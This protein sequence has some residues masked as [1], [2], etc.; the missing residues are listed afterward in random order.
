MKFRFVHVPRFHRPF[1]SGCISGLVPFPCS[2]K[3]PGC[4]SISGVWCG[5]LWANQER[6]IQIILD[7]I[8]RYFRMLPSGFQR[9]CTFVP[10]MHAG[11]LP[12]P[13]PQHLSPF[14]FLMIKTGWWWGWVKA[15]VICIPLTP[16]DVEYFVFLMLVCYLCFSSWELY[17][18]LQ[19]MFSLRCSFSQCLVFEIMSVPDTSLLSDV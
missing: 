11:S 15:V 14:V 2:C 1:F 6:Y 12:L 4:E 13:S 19:F 8:S 7:L 17:S 10:T 5:I 16:K 9:G 18:V 3:E